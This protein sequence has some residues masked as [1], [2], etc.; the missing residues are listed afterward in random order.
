MMLAPTRNAPK[1]EGVW[2]VSKSRFVDD[3]VPGAA[4]IH[5][6]CHLRDNATW[7]HG[8]MAT[9]VANRRV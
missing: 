8:D 7:R 4:Q 6:L 2:W 9:V 1:L 5:P 3:G